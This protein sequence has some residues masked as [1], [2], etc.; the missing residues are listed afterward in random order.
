MVSNTML[1]FRATLSWNIF[2]FV[3]IRA[4]H[5]PI[6]NQLSKE[7]YHSRGALDAKIGG[8]IFIGRMRNRRGLK[9]KILRVKKK[10]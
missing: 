3:I 5:S 2:T 6:F 10:V 7:E 4:Q 1:I 9:A 8:N